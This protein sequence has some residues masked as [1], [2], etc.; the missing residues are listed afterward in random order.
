MNQNGINLEFLTKVLRY[1]NREWFI[2]LLS[3]FVSSTHIQENLVSQTLKHE[4]KSIYL[5]SKVEEPQ[6]SGITF[7]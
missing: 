5:F 4:S 2:Y 6:S 3:R 7:F 1:F